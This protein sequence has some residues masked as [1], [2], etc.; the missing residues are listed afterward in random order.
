[1]N[2]SRF[3]KAAH[4]SCVCGHSVQNVKNLSQN[5][6]SLQTPIHENQQSVCESDHP[7]SVSERG[8]NGVLTAVLDAVVA[9]ETSVAHCQFSR[10]ADPC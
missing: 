9:C 10:A 5:N 4:D 1:M 3:C 2:A 6:K 7:E 8:E